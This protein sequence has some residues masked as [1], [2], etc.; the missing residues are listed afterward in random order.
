MDDVPD[1]AITVG[2]ELATRADRSFVVDPFFVRAAD[3]AVGHHDSSHL[4]LGDELKDGRGD[5]GIP[6]HI[7]GTVLRGLSPLPHP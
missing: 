7:P 2:P 4:E 3:D 1:P 5:G 6:A